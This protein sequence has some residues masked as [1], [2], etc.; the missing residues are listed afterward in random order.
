MHILSYTVD[1]KHPYKHTVNL[2]IGNW[3]Q[4]Q[5]VKIIFKNERKNK[6]KKKQ[7]SIILH[8]YV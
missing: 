7:N 2:S 5:V 4:S 1:S 6:N 8:Y 3:T